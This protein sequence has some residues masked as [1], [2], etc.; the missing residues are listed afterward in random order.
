[1]ASEIADVVRRDDERSPRRK[2]VKSRH[3]ESEKAAHDHP[4]H[5]I[6]EQSGRRQEGT[7]RRQ[8]T[9]NIFR[10]GRRLIGRYCRSSAG[11]SFN[12]AAQ[13]IADRVDTSGFSLLLRPRHR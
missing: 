5:A 10:N 3:A 12:A 4:V 13:Q 7:G 6:E 1:M 9:V 2:V 8:P 11:L